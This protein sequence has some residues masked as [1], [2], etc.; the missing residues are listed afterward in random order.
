MLPPVR[1]QG[2]HDERGYERRGRDGAEEALGSRPSS[3]RETDGYGERDENENSERRLPAARAVEEIPRD[4]EM[5]ESATNRPIGGRA[6]ARVVDVV[7]DRPEIR[8]EL[9]ADGEER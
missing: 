3:P 1:R 8:S 9:S 5:L 4:A 7:R 2:D 6:R